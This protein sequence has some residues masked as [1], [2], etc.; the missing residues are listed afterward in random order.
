MLH[1]ILAEERVALQRLPSLAPAA[2]A[3]HEAKARTLVAKTE[4][5]ALRALFDR[6]DINSS[7]S[8]CAE[9]LLLAFNS[10]DVFL[11]EKEFAGLVAHIDVDHDGR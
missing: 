7:G 5:A 2:T 9:E 10:L 4:P 1:K 3:A 6:L 11:D 8:V